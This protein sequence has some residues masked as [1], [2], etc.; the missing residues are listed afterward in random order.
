MLIVRK[1]ADLSFQETC[2]AGE[3]IY[4]ATVLA[5]RYE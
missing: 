1:G 3:T 5:F 4:Y 2:S